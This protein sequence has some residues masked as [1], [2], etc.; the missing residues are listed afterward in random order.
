MY[1][2]DDRHVT[3]SYKLSTHTT[4]HM[5]VHGYCKEGMPLEATEKGPHADDTLRRGRKGRDM[6]VRGTIWPPMQDLEHERFFFCALR[7][8]IHHRKSGG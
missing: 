6:E 2:E 7:V 4:T 1:K 8:L 5:S 3:F